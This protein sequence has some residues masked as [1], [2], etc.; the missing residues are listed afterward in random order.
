VAT[1]LLFPRAPDR[2]ANS[3]ADEAGAAARTTAP[4]SRVTLTPAPSTTVPSPTTTIPSRP[5]VSMA[6]PAPRR[7]AR[8]VRIVARARGTTL[9]F[10]PSTEIWAFEAR[11]RLVCLHAPTGCF[12]VDL[13]LREVESVLVPGFLRVH[14]NWLV[15]LAKVRELRA[16]GG[17]NVLFVGDSTPEDPASPRGIEVPIARERTK[18]VRRVLLAGAFGLRPRSDGSRLGLTGPS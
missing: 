1:P 11:G 8:E 14:R 16:S 18:V 3:S 15:G 12:D 2:P 17:A 7:E 10:I 13:S 6:P 5:R 4:S 9:V